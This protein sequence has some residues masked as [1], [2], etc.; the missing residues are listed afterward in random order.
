MEVS[1]V[2]LHDDKRVRHAFHFKPNRSERR[3]TF[4][5]V[6]ICMEPKNSSLKRESGG[7]LVTDELDDEGMFALAH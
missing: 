2:S 7:L 3:A 4:G 5:F 6:S 1:T